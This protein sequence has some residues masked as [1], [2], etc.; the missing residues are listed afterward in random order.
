[1]NEP[2]LF[3]IN[4]N[5]KGSR[6]RLYKMVRLYFLYYQIYSYECLTNKKRNRYKNAHDSMHILIRSHIRKNYPGY[7]SWFPERLGKLNSFDLH[8][9][10]N[11]CFL[12]TLEMK[13]E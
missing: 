6:Y 1:M 5:S 3:K 4:N 13:D 11:L 12:I 8:H 9:N 7:I 2:Y 10:I